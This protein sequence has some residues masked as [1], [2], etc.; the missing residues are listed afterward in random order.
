MNVVKVYGGLG[1]QLFQYA[2]GKAMEANGITVRYDLSWFR[3]SQ[4]PPRPFILDCFNVRYRTGPLT[5]RKQYD[6][7]GL[8][9]AKRMEFL[10]TD[11]CDFF[12]YW[13]HPGYF[14]AIL[15]KLKQEFKVRKEL[16]TD[17]YVD[18]RERIICK[19]SV[20]LHVRR[21]DYVKINGH[22]LLSLEY[23]QKALGL[24]KGSVYVFSDDIPWCRENFP[25]NFTFVEM[26]DYLS[27]DLMR[28]CKHNIIANST[29]SWW[30]AYLNDNPE[31]IVVTPIQWRKDKNDPAMSDP[32]FMQPAGW[33]R[34]D[35]PGIIT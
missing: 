11:N 26:E 2:F 10:T 15:S 22:F 32:D 12:G 21:T 30:A 35:S 29:Y 1:N 27:F 4:E 9:Y 33:I 14:A 13:Q 28:L 34:I 7:V 24:V 17:E 23:Y 5:R 18:L 25:S 20:S 19:P 31:K 6:E 3:V 8:H 16:Y